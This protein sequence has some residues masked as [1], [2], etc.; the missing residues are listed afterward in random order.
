ME[1]I[2]PP[3]FNCPQEASSR[4]S[5]HSFELFRGGHC[6]STSQRSGGDCTLDMVGHVIHVNRINSF[7]C[8]RIPELSS[9]RGR[10]G[11]SANHRRWSIEPTFAAPCM[12]KGPAENARLKLRDI[13]RFVHQ[14]SMTF[15]RWM[16]FFTV[17]SFMILLSRK[18][19]SS[20]FYLEKGA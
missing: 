19:F 6:I 15:W 10:R 1:G 20:F 18:K 12:R 3:D 5:L 2:P 16:T 14:S 4:N 17:Y 7:Y 8:R 11:R 13:Q 9:D